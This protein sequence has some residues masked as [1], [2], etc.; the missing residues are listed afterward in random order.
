MSVPKE[1]GVA[2]EI[3]SAPAQRASQVALTK[4]PV[5]WKPRV[6]IQW[7]HRW[8]TLTLGILLIVTTFSGIVALFAFDLN[9]LTHP[10]FYRVTPAEK[11]VSWD[12]AREA[13][14][15]GI[16][17]D[18]TLKDVEARDLVAR[19]GDSY[20]F[21]LYNQADESA[22][23]AFVD[24]GTGAYLGHYDHEKT[25]WGWFA[26]LHYELFADDIKFTFPAWLPAWAKTY[27]GENLGE[28]VLKHVALLLLIMVVTGAYLWWPGIKRLLYGV[29]VRRHAKGYA[30][31]YEW[32]KVL[33]FI[34]LP[35]LLMWALTGL[36]F[37]AP[38]S[39]G[40]KWLWYTTTLATQPPEWPEDLQSKPTGGP[41]ISTEQA[42]S[43][44]LATVPGASLVSVTMPTVV[45]GTVSLWLSEGID[46][47]AYG[48][49]P[50][51][52]SITLDAYSGA[53]LDNSKTRDTGW[54]AYLYDWWFYPIHAGVAVSWP[55]RLIWG[56]FGLLPTFLGFTGVM[57]WWLK[58]QKG[59]E[60]RAHRKGLATMPTGDD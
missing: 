43:I 13:V 8:A 33:G 2:Q 56:F 59:K 50:G 55:I 47:Y 16:A 10:Q 28:A 19:P 21:Y 4:L 60:R 30:W 53:V 27:I 51:Q 12:A 26:R 54:A 32:H 5:G 25:I 18:P 3:T 39:D 49:W 14:K 15:Q 52:V 17:K 48:E 58:R 42:K 45:T 24:P 46:P 29:T 40:I 35:F 37:Y 44:A 1:V 38:Y 31:H 9:R 6:W 7:L 34:S 11:P 41:M 57:Q 22:G 20:Q 36:N 23:L